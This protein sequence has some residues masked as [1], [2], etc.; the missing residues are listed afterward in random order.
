VLTA[1][2]EEGPRVM[3]EGG[4]GQ[5][6]WSPV[7]VSLGQGH[8]LGLQVQEGVC[9]WGRGLDADWLSIRDMQNSWD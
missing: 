8:T 6:P 1:T 3:E 9:D 4:G 7:G 5:R 2:L